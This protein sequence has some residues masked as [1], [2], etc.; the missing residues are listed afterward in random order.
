MLPAT[1]ERVPRHTAEFLN[2]R[3]EREIEQRVRFFADN[4]ALI[5]QRLRELDREWD[6]ERLL[7]TNAS[8]LALT[9]TI[10]GITDDRRWLA[11]PLLVTAFL[12]Q[13][14]LQGWCPPI[15]ILRRLGY[16]T[17]RE[18][19]YER[20]ALKGLRGDFRAVAESSDGAAR[21]QQALAAARC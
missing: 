3:I 8:A 1:V 11:L 18:I 2:R 5:E 21:A 14:A 19:E 16:R 4:P 20:V 17:A 7:E 10:L 13:H 9:G 12:L 15:P 6:V